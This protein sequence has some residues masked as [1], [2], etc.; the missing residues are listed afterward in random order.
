MQDVKFRQELHELFSTSELEFLLRESS[1]TGEEI[2]GEICQLYFSR[3]KGSVEVYLPPYK[4]KTKDIEIYFLTT[5][6]RENCTKKE[7]MKFLYDTKQKKLGFI[8]VE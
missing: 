5:T 7:F 2:N 6:D 3:D 8:S 1:V 4:V